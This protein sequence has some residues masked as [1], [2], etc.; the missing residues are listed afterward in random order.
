MISSSNWN[1]DL[2]L[3]SQ[4]YTI[5]KIVKKNEPYLTFLNI[6]QLERGNEAGQ[7]GKFNLEL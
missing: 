1:S 2:Q 4:F 3:H 5:L 7:K 6:S